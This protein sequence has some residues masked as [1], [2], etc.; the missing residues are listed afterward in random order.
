MLI[1]KELD[2]SPDLGAGSPEREA[3]A[4]TSILE[5]DTYK[6]LEVLDSDDHIIYLKILEML[7]FGI[8][9]YHHKL[10]K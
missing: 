6:E 9:I 4:T 1:V 2:Q 5:K 7:L 3:R 10:E 8:E